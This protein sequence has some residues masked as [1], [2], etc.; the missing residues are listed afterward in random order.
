MDVAF[1]PS[2]I[3]SS[4]GAILGALLH[5]CRTCQ[6]E[7]KDVVVTHNVGAE[8]AHKVRRH[9]GET[10]TESVDFWRGI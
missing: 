6:P 1:V 3:S 10:R 5:R 9:A 8:D 4:T 2:P 7:K